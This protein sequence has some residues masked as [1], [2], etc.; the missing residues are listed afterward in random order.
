MDP[1]I[2]RAVTMIGT[3]LLGTLAVFGA[4]IWGLVVATD[5]IAAAG[6]SAAVLRWSA[7]LLLSLAALCPLP[8]LVADT[9]RPLTRHRSVRPKRV[10][11]GIGLGL[12]GSAALTFLA[13]LFGG[14]A[15]R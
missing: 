12:A 4:G 5:R 2:R 11:A 10:V 15:G 8:W 9:I 6:G 14:G 13:A 3:V 1:D 7:L